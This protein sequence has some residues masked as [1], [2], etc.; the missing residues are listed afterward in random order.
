MSSVDQE[1][2]IVKKWGHFIE[3]ESTLDL[4][5][6]INDKYKELCHQRK[7]VINNA[8]KSKPVVPKIR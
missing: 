2:E 3:E 4:L 1:E 6:D 7:E 8:E 5:I